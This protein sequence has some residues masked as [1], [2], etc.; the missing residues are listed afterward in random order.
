MKCKQL[1]QQYAND[2]VE[3]NQ[4]FRQRLA[5]RAHLLMCNSCRHFIQRLR[6][7]RAVLLKIGSTQQEGAD[8][9]EE[10]IK[11]LALQMLEEKKRNH[12]WESQV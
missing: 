8:L 10:N 7:T 12:S 3:G 11:A 2:Y 5:V 1:A 4:G 6:L 9:Q